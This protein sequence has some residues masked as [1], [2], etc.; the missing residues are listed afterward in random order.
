MDNNIK[1][2]LHVQSSLL[3]ALCATHPDPLALEQSF[4]FHLRQSE[5]A[6]A[7]SPEVLVMISAWAKTFRLRL[8]RLEENLLEPGPT[9][10][11]AD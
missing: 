4:D 3:M 8:E 10:P 9:S 1:A 6:T 11:P 5:D 2:L 7:R